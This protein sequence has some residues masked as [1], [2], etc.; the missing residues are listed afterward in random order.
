MLVCF[1]FLGP[2]SRHMEV[3]RLEVE[4]ELHLPAYAMATATA[5]QDISWVLNGHHS[6]RQLQILNP[7]FKVRDR[8][9][10]LMDPSRVPYGWATMGTTEIHDFHEILWLSPRK[11]RTTGYENMGRSHWSLTRSGGC[12]HLVKTLMVYLLTTSLAFSIKLEGSSYKNPI[13]SISVISL[14]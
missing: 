9:C 11:V 5:T 3:P 7:L 14:S 8:T 13:K 2:H 1:C 10:I 6:S 4:S 12:F